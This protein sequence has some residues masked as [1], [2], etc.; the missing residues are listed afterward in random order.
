MHG[1]SYTN[2]KDFNYNTKTNSKYIYAFSLYFIIFI[3]I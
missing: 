1:N 3:N 2:I